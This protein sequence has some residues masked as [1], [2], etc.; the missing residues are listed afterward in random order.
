MSR[1]LTK[2][3]FKLAFECP[4]KLFYDDKPD[5]Y[6]N[7]GLDDSFLRALADGGL[8][9]RELAKL[10]YPE[11]I[12][13]TNTDPEDALEHTRHLLQR[14]DVTLFE[15][16]FAYNDLFVRAD[17][18][19]K[20]GDRMRLI[21]V[22]SKSFYS[23]EKFVTRNGP[24]SEWKPYYYDVAFQKYVLSGALPGYHISSH[25]FLIY[26]DSEATVDSLYQKFYIAHES[27]ETRIEV[28]PG[29]PGDPIMNLVDTDPVV[30]PII[31]GI[32]VLNGEE[33][34]FPEYLVRIARSYVAG[35]KIL[36]GVR[37]IC[38]DCQFRLEHAEEDGLRSGFHECWLEQT[39]LTPEQL[40]EPLVFDIWAYMQKDILLSQRV[41][42]QK[43]VDQTPFE[44]RAEERP[45]NHPG[46]QLL[47]VRKSAEHDGSL[48]VD[49]KGLGHL[50]QQVTYPLH[51]IDFET[52]RVPIPF[53]LGNRP[54]EQIAFQFSHHIM[55]TDGTI[56]HQ[57]QWMSTEPGVFPN[58][59]FVRQLRDTLS[60][61]DGSVFR[62]A[63]HENTVL[64]EIREQLLASGETDCEQLTEFIE[65]ITHKSEGHGKKKVLL[66]EGRRNMI[67]MLEWIVGYYYDPKT[68]GSNS[69]KAILPSIIDR[70][71]YLQERYSRPVYGDQIPS[72]NFGPVSWIQQEGD[73]FRDPY[74]LLPPILD[75]HSRNELDLYVIGE[76]Q[77]NEGGAAMMAY[78]YM[79]FPQM[80]DDERAATI[81][82]LYR[83]CELD[84]LA[85]V[86]LWEGLRDLVG[87]E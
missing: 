73:R 81:N 71:P 27:G 77:I 32:E 9:V 37:K 85:M 86:M 6:A 59:D 56:R 1:Y 55:E 14:D 63:A 36:A 28:Q 34:P 20:K 53:H 3:K 50:M 19:E 42:L 18:L 41:Y 78:N 33:L 16:A 30:D 47:Q 67:D 43:D 44:N 5:V 38:R 75:G 52:T 40:E 80:S 45:L 8:Q 48:Y 70:S 76:D 60:T 4:T 25:L 69:L 82:A 31:G 15:A 87:G 79:Q 11:G 39:H 61:D 13:I 66:W 22:K 51:F 62:Y 83:Y 54:N 74:A 64:C 26:K 65:S 10:Y 2:S 12:E 49:R 21:E 72:L 29:N 46:R 57:H 23:D 7:K 58:F 68:K 24:T 17:I 35:E 84:T